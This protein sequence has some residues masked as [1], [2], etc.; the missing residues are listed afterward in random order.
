VTAIT[1]F[2]PIDVRYN[3]S[4]ETI[5]SSFVLGRTDEAYN[6]EPYHD[7]SNGKR[8]ARIIVY[9]Y[10]DHSQALDYA[11][12]MRR[13]GRAGAEPHHQPTFAASVHATAPYLLHRRAAQ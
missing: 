10:T 9:A 1:T 5:V 3:V 6:V 11:W 12:I 4:A 8:I 13:Y 7:G 2:F